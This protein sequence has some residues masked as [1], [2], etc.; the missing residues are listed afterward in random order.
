MPLLHRAP[1]VAV[2]RGVR[3]PHARHASTALTIGIR[4]EDPARIWE[5][6]CPLTPLAIHDLVRNDGLTVLVQ[7]CERRVYSMRE[8]QEA[9][10]TPHDTLA[11][12]H[13]VLGI[14]ETPP[15]DVLADPLPLRAPDGTTALVPR[16]HLM[17][18]HTHKGQEY[19]TPLLSKFL[20]PSLARTPDPTRPTL[21]DYELL[22]DDGGKRT[23]GFGW[24]AGV[25]GALES[26]AA[27]AHALLE[28]GVASPFLSTP[29]P[30]THPSLDSLKEA[31]RRLVGD[32][33]AS[34]GTPP[35]L[36]PV[37]ICVTGTG[38]V[39]QGALDL[40][41]ELPIQHVTVDELPQ[42][43]D[44]P[45]TDLRK[46]YVL[47]ALPS[48]YFVR[49]DG[50]AYARDDYYAHPDAYASVF[51]TRIAPY[52]T[53]MLNGGGWAQGFPRIMRNADL[54]PAMA[55]GRFVCVGDISC[56]VE[57]SLEFLP[58]HSTLSAPHF[59][60]RPAGHPPALP[61]LTMMAVDILP[62]ALPA[63]ASAHFSAVLVPHLRAVAA[64]YGGAPHGDA[65]ERATVARAGVLREEHRWLED[66]VR[67][68][69]GA[70]AGEVRPEK[71]K[72]VLVLG[73]GMVAAPAVDEIARHAD[74]R[75]VV[76]SNVLADA[77]RLAGGHANAAAVR[78]DMADAPAVAALV[79][80]A[81]VVVSL[82]PVPLHPQVAE[83]C[84]A[85][86]KHLVTASYISPAMRAL[87]SRAVAADVLL[88]NEIGLDP[89]IDH[90]S[91]IAMLET[92]RARGR[93]V[94]SFVSFCGGLPAPEH[95][96][97]PLRYKFSWSP[98][99]VLGA[100][101]ND[102]RFKLGGAV[103]E[104]PGRELLAQGFADLP[105]SDV[106]KLEGIANRDS[107]PYAETYGLGKVEDLRTLVRGT[108]RCTPASPHSCTPSR[109]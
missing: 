105:V 82:L 35:S 11:P 78:V 47:H 76:A 72:N 91:A 67:A 32:R 1:F 27:L 70:A 15:A 84:L 108:I 88:L 80:E 34:E 52:T 107:L 31:L 65:I 55:R 48:D 20:N 102:A 81:D 56:D 21:I 68:W 46:I 14:K 7:P 30:H 19:N 64:A 106:L 9:G 99:G 29:R 28:R 69:R 4:R 92:L 97:V 103:R 94:V 16:T 39:A 37:V 77:E 51:P 33:I 8:L 23:V 90:C 85:H 58:R 66:R 57:G 104:I 54:V 13:I 86:R 96:D 75:V 10:A 73:S 83:L 41:A 93:R 38:K 18:S 40:L 61:A 89:G 87:H 17:F 101:L 43:V 3:P 6:R 100:A 59:S 44:S 22:T 2:L 42:L 60:V 12:A 63:A 36:G 5:R 79:A 24:F 25:A 50:G 62:T 71:R 49:T 45:D 109:P 74:V 95:A 98:R 26:L 53:L